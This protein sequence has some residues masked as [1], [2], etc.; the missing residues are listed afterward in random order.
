MQRY[1]SPLRHIGR[2]AALVATLSVIGVAAC[3]SDSTGVAGNTQAQLAF[4]ASGSANADAASAAVVPVSSAGHTLDLSAIAI[5]ISRAELKL[6]TTDSCDDD[7]IND[8]R[9]DDH[10][11]RNGDDNRNRGNCSEL[12][13]GTTVVNLPLTGNVVTIPADVIPAGT[14]REL[15]LRVTQVELKGTFDSTAFVVMVPVNARAEVEFDTPLVVAAG[16]PTSITVNVP[17]N[18]IFV[19]AD[20]SLID[21][22]KILSTPSLLSTVRA[23]ILAAFHAFEDRNHDGRDD[24]RGPGN[25]GNGKGGNGGGPGPG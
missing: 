15:E 10:G 23:R 1:E 8:D 25:S 22:A 18:N 19:N 21:P 4:M 7:D 16:T 13:V 20:G 5:T 14:F 2:V 3:S 12:K 11:N 17:V 6:A 24:H 9:S